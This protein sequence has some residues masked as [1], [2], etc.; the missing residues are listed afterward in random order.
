M[1]LSILFTAKKL[2]CETDENAKEPETS[3]L[4]WSP[5][6]Q[7]FAIYSDNPSPV[8]SMLGTKP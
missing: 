6:S 8:P 5:G 2:R 1:T 4:R 7:Y 3:Q